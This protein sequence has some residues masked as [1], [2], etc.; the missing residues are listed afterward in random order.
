MLKFIKIKSKSSDGFESS[1]VESVSKIVALKEQD[2]EFSRSIAKRGKKMMNKFLCLNSLLK[3][4][5]GK[6]DSIISQPTQSK[7]VKSQFT[8]HSVHFE[9]EITARNDAELNETGDS[10]FNKSIQMNL[11]F[12]ENS[13]PLKNDIVVNTNT[14][15]K[16]GGK[17]YLI[18]S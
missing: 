4:V 7:Q 15:Q 18:S 17:N 3:N 9:K 6:D 16:L 10:S 1:E 8:S 12:Q 11:S 2:A 5:F 14:I 13:F